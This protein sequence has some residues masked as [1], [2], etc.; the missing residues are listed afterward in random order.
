MIVMT[1][2]IFEVDLEYPEELHDLH[3]DYPLAPESIQIDTLMLSDHASCKET[4]RNH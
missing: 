2:A 4:F 3:T 1:K